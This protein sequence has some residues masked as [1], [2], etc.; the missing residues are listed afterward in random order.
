MPA[1]PGNGTV[2][3]NP[4]DRPITRQ[5]DPLADIA[6]E[7]ATYEARLP[8]LLAHEGRFVLIKGDQVI[9]FFDSFDAAYREGRRRFGLVPLLAKQI[10][11]VEPVV[12]IPHVVL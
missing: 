8:E 12:Y 3:G 11:A 2:S 9:G 7:V 4:P 10:A 1:R 5:S 6:Q